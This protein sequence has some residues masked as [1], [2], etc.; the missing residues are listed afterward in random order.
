MAPG[1][2]NLVP[3]AIYLFLLKNRCLGVIINQIKKNVEQ[4]K[5]QYRLIDNR[6]GWNNEY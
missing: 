6:T 5:K 4:N 2:K 3:G 1:T